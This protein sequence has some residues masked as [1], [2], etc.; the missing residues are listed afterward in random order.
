MK[1]VKIL[2]LTVV[3]LLTMALP[4]MAQSNSPVNKGS[5]QGASFNGS[6]GTVDTSVDLLLTLKIRILI[7]SIT[8]PTIMKK[9]NTI[10]AVL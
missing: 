9:T 3:F 10:M 6:D 1:K 4:A 5:F 8:K 7:S 2:I